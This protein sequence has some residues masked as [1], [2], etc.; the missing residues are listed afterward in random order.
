[1]ANFT[2]ATWECPDCTNFGDG[3]KPKQCP[4]CG[5]RKLFAVNYGRER[6]EDDGLTYADPRDEREERRRG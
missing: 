2:L 3:K 5:S 4:E 6:D 1:M